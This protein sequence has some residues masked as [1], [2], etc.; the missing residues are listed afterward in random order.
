MAP[1]NPP[2]TRD[3][4]ILTLDMYFQ[5]GPSHISASHPTVTSLSESLNRLPV[6][7]V[8]PDAERFRNANGVYMKLS[9][10]LRFDDSYAGSGLTHG[11]KLEEEVWNEFA[12][13]KLRL[14]NV[15]SAIRAV[16]ENAGSAAATISATDE[17]YQAPEGNILA[18]YH[19][20]RERNSSLVRKK[21]ALVLSK[22]GVLA[23]E[24]CEFVF[25][26]KYGPLGQ[27]II[28]CHHIVPLSQ[29]T[30][31]QTTKLSD[32][33]L[34]CPNCHRMLHRGKDAPTLQTLRNIVR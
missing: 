11:G 17:D 30:P 27:D 14:R 18:G 13:D 31:E 22:T 9:N 16:S 28:D 3:E 26:E 20:Y 7:S 1:R 34:V 24:V 33:S 15:A 10:F 21:K 19:R 32:L 4:L 29:L 8:R 2:W 5:Q 6:H 23:C 25:S 12:S